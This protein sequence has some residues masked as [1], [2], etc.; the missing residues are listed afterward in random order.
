MRY[1]KPDI[2]IDVEWYRYGEIEL[3]FSN[4]PK[5]KLNEKKVKA[6]I[7]KLKLDLASTWAD[8]WQDCDVHK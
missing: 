6:L 8:C 5:K 3:Q 7:R 1:P 2:S 4:P